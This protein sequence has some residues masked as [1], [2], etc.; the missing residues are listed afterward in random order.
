[1]PHLVGLV[2]NR[3]MAES[4]RLQIDDRYKDRGKRSVAETVITIIDPFRN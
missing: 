2:S 4:I 1:M 3:R